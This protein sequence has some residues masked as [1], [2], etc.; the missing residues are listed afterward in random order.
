MHRENLYL[1]Q[2]AASSH[3]GD[4]RFNRHTD[5]VSGTR[6]KFGAAMVISAS[7][8]ACKSTHI[9]PPIDLE[10][11]VVIALTPH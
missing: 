6:K 10:V 5:P 1:L 2:H 11:R 8:G 4:P 3:S 7:C 9:T